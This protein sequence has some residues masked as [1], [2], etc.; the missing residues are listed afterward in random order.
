M[1]KRISISILNVL[2][3]L[4]SYSQGNCPF[5]S[6]YEDTIASPAFVSNMEEYEEGFVDFMFDPNYGGNYDLP[7]VVHVLHQTGNSILSDEQII[8]SL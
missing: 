8:R 6:V 4:C 1:K 5:E 2:L 3:F 7:V